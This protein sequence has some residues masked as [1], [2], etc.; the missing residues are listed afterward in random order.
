MKNEKLKT[1]L[2]AFE[3]A[4]NESGLDYDF[5]MSLDNNDKIKFKENIKEIIDDY[6]R[7]E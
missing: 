6:F 5:D 7:L 2:S 3:D 1:M 4:L